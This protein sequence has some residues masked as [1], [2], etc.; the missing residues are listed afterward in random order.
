M[1]LPPCFLCDEVDEKPVA[2]NIDEGIYLCRS[3][4]GHVELSVYGRIVDE[5]E[6]DEDK[7]VVA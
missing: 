6:D 7:Q 5:D 1:E 3:C 4:H 2:Y